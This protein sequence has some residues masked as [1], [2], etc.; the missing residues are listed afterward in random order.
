MVQGSS[1]WSGKKPHFL[2]V[3]FLSVK[4]RE[5]WFDHKSL[6]EKLLW[7]ALRSKDPKGEPSTAVRASSRRA[8]AHQTSTTG[9][10][11]AEA[12]RNSAEM[13]EEVFLIEKE[14]GNPLPSY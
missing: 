10:T 3:A 9:A 2:S 14:H 6:R 5:P 7:E 8:V 4:G 1:P 12:L 11:R 13:E